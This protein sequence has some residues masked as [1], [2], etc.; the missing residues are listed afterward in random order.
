MLK[1]LIEGRSTKVYTLAAMLAVMW[2]FSW[3]TDDG[4]VL[5][6]YQTQGVIEQ[7]YEK[8]YLIR[9]ADG[10]SVRVMREGEYVKGASVKLQITQYESKKERAKLLP[11]S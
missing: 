1:N 4:Q 10:R 7:I 6:S 8:A 3:W 9:L 11:K 5:K 2:L